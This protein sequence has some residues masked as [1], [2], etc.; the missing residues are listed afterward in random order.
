M[1][2]DDVFDERHGCK[3]DGHTHSWLHQQ[4][5][6][7][8]DSG[9]A[10]NTFSVDQSGDVNAHAQFGVDNGIIYDED[11]KFTIASITSTTGLP[12][13]Y[14]RADGTWVQTTNAGFSVL[15]T[16]TGRL[17]Y[18]PDGSGLVEV[19]NND[20]VNCHIVSTAGSDENGRV[21][22]IVGQQEYNTVI[23]AREGAID[24]INTIAHTG[25]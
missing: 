20:F 25:F 8:Y 21:F 23:E 4:V 11:I 18:N 19:G 3:M 1:L 2:F 15:T 6:A 14:H 7:R 12:I 22:A 13:V 17:A 5:G 10:L 24:E 9:L 16:G